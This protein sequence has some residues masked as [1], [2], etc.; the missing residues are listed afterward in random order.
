MLNNC[1][2]CLR[3]RVFL[4]EDFINSLTFDSFS[5]E[6]TRLE[7]SVNLAIALSSFPMLINLLNCCVSVSALFFSLFTKC[8]C[9]SF[10]S[11][12][13]RPFSSYAIA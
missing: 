4:V 7:V 11:L 8:I 2:Y 13:S 9:S 10:T 1:C 5:S 6:R 12:K 3:G